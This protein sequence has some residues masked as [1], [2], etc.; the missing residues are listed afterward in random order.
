MKCPTCQSEH[1]SKNG[2]RRGMQYFI[3]NHCR[4]QF[5]AYHHPRGY[6]EEVKRN[7][8]TMY[9]NGL[10]FRAIERVTGVHHTTIIHWVKQAASALPD[11]PEVE[12]IPIVA[13]LDEL[14]TYVG[15]KKNKIWLWTAVN[16][17]ASGILAWVIGDPSSKTFEPLWR[18]VESWRCA[19]HVTDGYV[20][21]KSFIE[22]QEQVISKTKMTRVEGENCRLRHYLARLHRE[23]LCYS[24][25][26]E[27]LKL[28]VR[29]LVHYL[30]TG[31]VHIPSLS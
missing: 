8:L 3:C 11:A 17:R 5:P 25:T 22:A 29:L 31:I 16:Q 12:K 15:R 6:P 26:V 4:K 1:L 19:W 18:I 23:T 28:S 9:L 2:R 20:V 21:Y 7:C 27:M 30:R 14:Q 13:Q 24:K 10:R